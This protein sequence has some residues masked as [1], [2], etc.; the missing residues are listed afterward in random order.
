[1]KKEYI[2]PVMESETFVANEYVAIC[3]LVTCKDG[4]EQFIYVSETGATDG[5]TSFDQK[6]FS[7]DKFDKIFDWGWYYSG[8]ING[9]EGETN[10]ASL[11]G[12][13]YPS[14]A[15]AVNVENTYTKF[16]GE[17]FTFNGKK[18][19]PNAS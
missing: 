16:G 7:D 18:R 3:E 1:M 14:H 19:G 2:K 13:T 9:E 17:S 8:T 15:H 4:G 6:S 11:F 5:R 10:L 12:N